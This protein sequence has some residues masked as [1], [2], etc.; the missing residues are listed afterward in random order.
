MMSLLTGCQAEV[1]SSTAYCSHENSMSDRFVTTS[2]V[3]IIAVL[4]LTALGALCTRRCFRE[5][6]PTAEGPTKIDRVTSTDTEPCF[7]IEFSYADCHSKEDR[8]RGLRTMTN[9]ECCLRI[10]VYVKRAAIN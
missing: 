8:S 6:F 2:G 7:L 3:S 9:E 10:V 1:P 4:V 5:D